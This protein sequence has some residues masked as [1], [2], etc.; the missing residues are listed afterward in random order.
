LDGRGGTIAGLTMSSVQAFV[1]I[2]AIGVG[3]TWTYLLFIKGRGRYPRASFTHKISRRPMGNGQVLLRLRVRIDN[4]GPVVMNFRSAIFRIQQV[5]PLTD[6]IGQELSERG[7]LVKDA[8]LEVNWPLVAERSREW[9]AGEMQ[10]EPGE[11]DEVACDFFIGDQLQT[12]EVYSYFANEVKPDQG[13]GWGVT[14]IYDFD[15]DS[16]EGLERTVE[17][18]TGK[19]IGS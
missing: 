2:I 15:C 1:E 11:S 12:V 4:T 3:G 5:L 10:I 16:A 13:I 9:R 17:D 18:L 19:E 6:E 7:D 14:T 8:R